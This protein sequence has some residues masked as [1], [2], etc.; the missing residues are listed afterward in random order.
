M[1]HTMPRHAVAVQGQ[2]AAPWPS[3]EAINEEAMRAAEA[4]LGHN[5]EQLSI[6]CGLSR[7]E[8][9]KQRER[10][11]SDGEGG[12]AAIGRQL[13]YRAALLLSAVRARYGTERTLPAARL[14]AKACGVQIADTL[15][16]VDQRDE[17]VT[18]LRLVASA[19]RAAGSALMEA[20]DAAIDGIDQKE[21]RAMAPTIDRAIERLSTLRT[22]AERRAS[23]E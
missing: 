1:T 10:A 23:G 7:R 11:A 21:A 5:V 4:A 15:P 22:L 17:R 3:Y 8:L 6:D 16:E 19:E 14:I 12:P 2:L 20:L 9:N 18:D 13:L